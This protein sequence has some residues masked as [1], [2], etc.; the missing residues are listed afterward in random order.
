[1]AKKFQACYQKE[2]GAPWNGKIVISF[3]NVNFPDGI[4]Q[5]KLG[6]SI[7]FAPASGKIEMQR[8]CLRCSFLSHD[9]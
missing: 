2:D 5:Y 1:M 8:S 9:I 7:Q 4:S 3:V 6:L